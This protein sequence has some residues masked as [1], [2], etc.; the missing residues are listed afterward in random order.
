MNPIPWKV[1]HAARKST[2]R[3]SRANTGVHVTKY[4]PHTRKLNPHTLNP[5][6]ANQRVLVTRYPH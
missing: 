2:I 6:R 3:V 5:E 4:K 1:L